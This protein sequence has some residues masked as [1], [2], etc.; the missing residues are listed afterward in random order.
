MKVL[1][2][3][4]SVVICVAAMKFYHDLFTGSQDIT[5]LF[6]IIFMYTDLK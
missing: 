5:S 4:Y 2:T 1:H 6:Y 3:S